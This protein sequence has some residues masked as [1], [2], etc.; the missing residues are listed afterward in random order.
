MIK[1]VARTASIGLVVI[2]ATTGVGTLARTGAALAAGASCGSLTP[3]P[4]SVG[5]LH[6]IDSV[7]P[8]PGSCPQPSAVARSTPGLGAVAT[9]KGS[10]PLLWNGGIVTGGNSPGALTV[11]PIYWTVP[12]TMTLP[13]N[14]S[15][16]QSQFLNDV[17][18]AANQPG[19][20]FSGLQQYTAGP[21]G[22]LHVHVTAGSPIVVSDAIPTGSADHCAHDTGAV[23]ADGS[24]YVSCVTAQGV[25][26]E[27]KNVV[28]SRHLPVDSAHAYALFTSEG[29]EGCEGKSNGAS[30]GICTANKA[31]SSGYCG[32]HSYSVGGSEQLL[33]LSMPWPV[34]RSA[35]GGTCGVVDGGYN[36]F[37]DGLQGAAGDVE[38]SVLS[39][40]ISETLT[41][42]TQS[43]WI[44]VDGAEIGDLCTG[45]SGTVVG[46]SGKGWSQVINGHHYVL[47]E[48]FSNATYAKNANRGCLQAW[49][50][51]SLTVVAPTSMK[52]GV[53]FVVT[54]TPSTALATLSPCKWTL[55]GVAVPKSTSTSATITL[56]D[57]GSHVITSTVTDVAGF[58]TTA[59]A[60]VLAR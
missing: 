58:S 43:G 51:P 53:P 7:S 34:Y 50:A 4:S 3:L 26:D 37:P 21:L 10:P 5:P 1:K 42:P 25:F 59:S 12:G 47:Q 28:I 15:S 32:Y 24:G 19:N 60:T 27:V 33:F 20:V 30:G 18:A 40:E 52:H 14:Y 31:S 57:A 9:Y 39:H 8:A 13:S 38:V 55:D 41:D 11:T 35:T 17:A 29:V 36:Q 56:A 49:A 54:C 16:F 6:G 45:V 22:R 44:T 48:E 46:P 23:Y 2:L